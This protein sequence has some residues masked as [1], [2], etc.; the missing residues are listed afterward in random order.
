MNFLHAQKF[1]AEF[2][3]QH[4]PHGRH[5]NGD[6]RCLPGNIEREGDHFTVDVPAKYDVGHES[7]FAQVTSDFLRY[8]REGK[9]PEWEVPN[10]LVKYGTIMQAYEMSRAK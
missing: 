8:L 9:L 2:V 6:R 1:D 5:T 7:H 3:F 10:M 4:P